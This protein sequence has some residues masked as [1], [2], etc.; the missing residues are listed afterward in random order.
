MGLVELEPPA[1]C[2]QAECLF[3]RVCAPPKSGS[4]PRQQG[5][6]EKG[7]STRRR[8][9]ELSGGQPC[10][11]PRGQPLQ[12]TAVTQKTD[13]LRVTV[14]EQPAALL[15][16]VEREQRAHGGP[17]PLLVCI[18]WFCPFTEGGNASLPTASGDTNV[19]ADVSF[20]ASCSQCESGGRKARAAHSRWPVCL[21]DP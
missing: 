6:T 2:L 7:S 15:Q 18:G 5:D 10:S 9:G 16:S 4:R 21:P 20:S 17:G 14:K 11:R 1:D 8:T 12:M 19:T 3:I 13:T